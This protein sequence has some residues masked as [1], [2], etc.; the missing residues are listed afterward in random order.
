MLDV[1]AVRALRFSLV[2]V[3]CS[4]VVAGTSGCGSAGSAGNAQSS[5]GDALSA[6]VASSAAYSATA[7]VAFAAA[8]WDDGVGECA[9]FTSDSLRAGHLNIPEIT[10]VPD[11]V[12]ALAKYHYEE[13]GA[14]A[15]A[16]GKLGDVVVFSDAS[17]DDFC[18]A[19]DSDDDNCGHV[20]LVTVAGTSDSSI[21]VDCH[22]TAHHEIAVADILGGGYS[23]YRVYHLDGS[24][25]AGGSSG[26]TP[27]STDDDCNQGETG[28]DVVC[29]ASEGYCI[30]GCH[31]DEDCPGEET[32]AHTSPHWSCQ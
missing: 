20:C 16:A 5:S 32:C 11:L 8:H 4:F 7:A 17:G 18:L 14:G 24:G 31:S 27:C 22:N 29:A 30:R 1:R 13:H 21:R 2:S 3:L 15:S 19:G 25:S 9:Q 28:T 12:T 10:W 23:S 26:V 6:G